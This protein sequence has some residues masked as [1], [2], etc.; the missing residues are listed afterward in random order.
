MVD[1]TYLRD[2]NRLRGWKRQLLA[3]G[4]EVAQMLEDLLAG[5]D[6]DLG[7]GIPELGADDKELR[8]RR[9]LELIDRGI[10]RAGSDRFGRCAVCGVAVPE[11]VLDERPWTERCADHAV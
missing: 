2:S 9:F 4:A 6:V 8:L 7:Q 5:K 1:D 11:A 10:K 3:K